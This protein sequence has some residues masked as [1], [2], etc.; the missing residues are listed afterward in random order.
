MEHHPPGDPYV[1]HGGDRGCARLLILLR[2]VARDLPQGAVIHLETTDP[3]APIDLP[4]WC[5]MT[6]HEYLGRVPGEGIPTYGVR[7]P[8][9]VRATD[10]ASPW[11]LA[12]EAA[13]PPD[14]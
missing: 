13:D 5:R 6:G 4:A 2:D 8:E 1:L 11:R 10:P 9:R 12:P 3:V 7:V 14:E